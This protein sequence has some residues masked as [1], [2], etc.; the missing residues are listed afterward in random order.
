M[1][2]IAGIVNFRNSAKEDIL[3]MNEAMLHRGPDAGDYYLDDNNGVVFGHRR[4]SILDLSEN[5][6]QPMQ[7]HSKRYVICYNGEVYNYKEIKKDLED[8]YQVTFRGNSDTETILEAFEIY[9]VRQTLGKIKGMFAIA[10]YDKDEKKIY[11]MRDRVGE[12]PLY[13]GMVKESFVFASDIGCIKSLS[14]FNNPINTDVLGLYFQHGYIPAPYSI[15]QGIYKLKPGTLLTLSVTNLSYETE[16]YFDMKEIAKY[17]QEHLFAGSE[18]EAGDELERLLK[19]AVRGQMISDV[20]LG[21]FLSGG[22]DSSL[23]V[24][25][26]QSVSDVPVR[27]FTIGFDEKKY[28]EAEFAREIANHLGTKHTELYVDKE[29]GFETV[30]QVTKAFTEPFADSSQIP[31]MMV[32]RMTKE[33]VTVSLSGD[34]GDELFCGYNTYKIAR[35]DMEVLNKK[36]AIIPSGMKLTL[37]STLLNHAGKAAG[38]RYKLGNYLTLQN[39]ETDYARHGLED[40]LSLRLPLRESREGISFGKHTILNCSNYDYTPGFLQGAENNLMLMDLLQYHPDDILVKVDRAGMLYSLETRIPLLDR[41]ILKFA[42]SLPL[43]Y[44]MSEGVTKRVMREVLYRHVPR[45]L[46]ERPKKGFSVPLN[47]WL[48]EGSMRTW[49]EDILSTGRNAAK[50]FVDVK[51]VDELWKNYTDKDV[52]NEKLWYVLMLYQWMI[53]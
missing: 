20:P 51:L 2:G 43:E 14:Y 11:L 24:S 23:I 19:D 16:P 3:R 44:K 4:L 5:G 22:I 42:W 30:K 12:K 29:Y 18:K 45:E 1:C 48:K 41:D 34:G 53:N 10:L 52:W 6:A 38:M 13:F 31:T 37:G 36:F 17:G 27:T 9:G 46:I 32:S 8:N 21:A 50:D 33:H 28:N 25:M 26:M 35:R 39:E 47:K 15:Y 7:S 40:R 49:A